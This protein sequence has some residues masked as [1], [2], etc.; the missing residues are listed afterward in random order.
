MNLFA[1]KLNP[2]GPRRRRRGGLT[3][4]ELMMAL[5]IMALIGATIAGMLSAV[6]YGTSSDSDVRQL[7]ARNKMVALRLNA[8]VRGS[9]MV[10]GSGTSSNE[11]WVVLWVRDL[12][13][14]GQPSLRELRLLEFDVE[15]RTLSSYVAPTGTTDV[16]YTTAD[17]FDAIT[18]ALRGTAEFP[19]TRW[20]ND[21]DDFEISLDQ[22][23]P[24]AARTLS[25][26][27][28]LT[29]GNLTDVTVGTVLLRN[30]KLAGTR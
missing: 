25:Y 10:L 22:S 3:L 18:N 28:S 8:A 27:L 23:D 30:N 12:D 2:R 21:A 26:R 6:A 1:P 13:D 4:I 15:A 24:Q 17:D 14:N 19:E 9:K 7:V 29:A 16:L 5:A 20:G 11:T